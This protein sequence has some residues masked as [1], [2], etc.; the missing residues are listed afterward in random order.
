[1][2]KTEALYYSDR[3]MKEC[4]ARLLSVDIV[5]GKIYMVFDRT[6]FFPGGGGQAQDRGYVID[7]SGIKFDICGINEKEGLIYH[8][9]RMAKDGLESLITSRQGIL[10]SIEQYMTKNID[11]AF[12]KYYFSDN[13]LKNLN[14]EIL[15]EKILLL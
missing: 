11:I 15:E 3:Y 14:I 6:L 10:D 13:I 9:V 1:M 2:L 5:G 4:Q 7:D 8:E 12:P